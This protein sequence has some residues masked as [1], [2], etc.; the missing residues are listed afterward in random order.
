MSTMSLADF[1]ATITLI[2]VIQK[3]IF[4]VI[5]SGN[6]LQMNGNAELRFAIMK[7]LKQSP[8]DGNSMLNLL[9]VFSN[10]A[11]G[12]F[13]DSTRF[14]R[15]ATAEFASGASRITGDSFV[16]RY[17]SGNSSAYYSN[18]PFDSILR[19]VPVNSVQ[20]NMYMLTHAFLRD[21]VGLATTGFPLKIQPCEYLVKPIDQTTNINNFKT[22]AT[23]ELQSGYII[24]DNAI[25]VYCKKNGLSGTISVN[26]NARFNDMIGTD[27]TVSSITSISDYFS[28]AK[29]DYFNGKIN[30]NSGNDIVLNSRKFDVPLGITIT[31]IIE[32]E[33]V[34]RHGLI[35]KIAGSFT[36]KGA[37]MGDLITLRT[38][39]VEYPMTWNLHLGDMLCNF[40]RNV[41]DRNDST[42]N[43]QLND[44]YFEIIA[45][46]VREA[47]SGAFSP[48]QSFTNVN[49]TV[50]DIF[51][52]TDMPSNSARAISLHAIRMAL[53]MINLLTFMYVGI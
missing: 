47:N 1:R 53:I 33:L 14:S 35:V 45:R 20:S 4:S 38:C 40:H 18:D 49:S 5:L 43:T 11:F 27:V 8:C 46:L 44:V 29:F 52:I 3:E 19:S 28:E 15:I 12:F 50:Q 39:N 26:T 17:I 16:D 22:P 37:A 9:R 6:S 21:G 36:L 41:I 13:T 31:I 51:L 23:N 2:Q 10:D 34:L 7:I 30:F 48:N 25:W 32:P 42:A 24:G